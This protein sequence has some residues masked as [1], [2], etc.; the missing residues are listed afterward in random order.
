MTEKNGGGKSHAPF[1]GP[2][3]EGSHVVFMES[4]QIKTKRIKLE[5]KGHSHVSGHWTILPR[6]LLGVIPWT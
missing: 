3:K 1:K 4:R 6:L 5:G 2:E